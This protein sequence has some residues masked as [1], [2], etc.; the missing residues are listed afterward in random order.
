MKK[1]LIIDDEEG[2]RD[3]FTEILTEEGYGI[4]TASNGKEGL[5]CLDQ[6]RFDLIMLDKKMPISGGFDFVGELKNRK[7]DSKILLITGSPSGPMPEG[8]SACLLKP[9]GVEELIETVKKLLNE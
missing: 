8:V 3:V 7:L 6:N 1:I 4:T 9:C 5:S 2:I